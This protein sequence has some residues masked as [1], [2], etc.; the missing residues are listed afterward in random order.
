MNWGHI[1]FS[2]SGRINRAKWWL[3][4]L[5]TII[6]AIVVG[7]LTELVNSDGLKAVLNLVYAVVSLWISLAAGAKRLHDL[8]RSGAWLVFFIGAPLLLLIIFLVMAGATIGTSILAGQTPGQAELMQVIGIVSI[9]GLIMFA[10]WLWYL[11]WFGCL[12]GTVGANQYGP[13]PLEGKI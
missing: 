9:L 2:F 10:I 4:V 6:I 5:V 11:I 3:T 7:V 1:L 13:D 12:R 8:N